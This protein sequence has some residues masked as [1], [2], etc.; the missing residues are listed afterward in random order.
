MIDKQ[1]EGSMRR[2]RVRRRVVTICLVLAAAILL[3]IWLLWPSKEKSNHIPLFTKPEVTDYVEEEP[4]RISISFWDDRT[5]SLAPY[6][7]EPGD[8]ETLYRTSQKGVTDSP[9]LTGQEG[10]NGDRF[11]RFTIDHT[12]H[13]D[14]NAYLEIDMSCRIV[15]HFA[16]GTTKDGETVRDWTMGSRVPVTVTDM[17]V[18]EFSF[19]RAKAVVG[20]KGETEEE[21]IEIAHCEEYYRYVLQNVW[22]AFRVYPKEH[23]S[24]LRKTMAFTLYMTL[25]GTTE[26]GE[27]GVLAEARLEIGWFSPFTKQG[28]GALSWE[29][30]LPYEYYTVTY[31][32]Y[33]QPES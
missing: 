11:V 18:V 1:E 6:L 20:T 27:V 8:T 30:V 23:S 16:Y 32:N 28:T 3:G 19:D 22:E 26:D 5:G 9:L 29:G 4:P 14:P 21:R 12:R 31:T 24:A 15:P 7:I 17:T 13:G 25:Y 2:L 33:T 10:K